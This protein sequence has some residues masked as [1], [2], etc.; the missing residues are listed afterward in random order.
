MGMRVIAIDWSGRAQRAAR[1]IWLCSV[2][3]GE[4]ERLENGRDRDAVADFLL[5]AR[6]RDP[7]MTVGLD[8]A[9][10]LPHWFVAAC[11]FTTAPDLWDLAASDGEEWLSRCA[12]PFWGRPGRRRPELAAHLRRADLEVPDVGGI[13][14]KS[15]FQVGGAGAVG[16]GSIRG[17]P[18]LKRLREGG[19]AI[20]PFD[21]PAESTI[22]EIYPRLLTDAVRK[23]NAESRAT[24]LR[25][26]FRSLDP[27]HRLAAE[28]SEDAFDA[29][30]SALVMARHAASFDAL[31]RSRDHL[32]RSE[33]R[34]WVPGPDKP[35]R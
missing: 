10:S 22:I 7:R 25:N 14:P 18:I 34:I 26:R 19:F 3:D 15:P 12:P 35:A 31:P 33:G 20:W 4:V 9:F 32:D 6:T 11:G 24:Y 28:R 2:R 8:F 17:M 21:A 30:V 27:E 1:T 5:D 16:T 23:S 13:R 29:L